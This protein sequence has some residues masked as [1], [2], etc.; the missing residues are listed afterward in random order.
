MRKILL[1]FSLSIII[2]SDTWCV[3]SSRTYFSAQPIFKPVSPEVL[4]IRREDIR[5][6]ENENY[7]TIDLTVFGGKSTN[8]NGLA[9]YF[10]P[11]GKSSILAGELGSRAVKSDRVDVI[12]NYFGVLTSNKPVNGD[13][14]NFNDYTF[15]SIVSLS[16]EQSYSGFGVVFRQHLSRYTDEGFW[17]SVTFP[18]INVKNNIGLTEKIIKRGGANGNNPK[19]PEGFYPNM[20]SAL[21]QQDWVFGK[22]KNNL[23]SKSGVSDLYLTIGY[24]SKKEEMYSLEGFVGASVPT[25]DAATAEFLFEPRVGNN[26]H[27]TIFSGTSMSFKVWQD[28]KNSVYYTFDTMGV[29]YIPNTQ[30]RSFDLKGKPWSRY[31]WVYLDSKSTTTS[32]GINVFTK[33]MCVDQGTQRDLN[34]AIIFKNCSGFEAEGGYHF[35]SRQS[36]KV[37]LARPWKAGPGIA[38]IDKDGKFT[39]GGVTRDNATINEY[40]GIK[41][42]MENGT[43]IFREIKQSDI[44]L[45]SAQHPAIISHILYLSLAYHWDENCYPKFIGAGGS[46]EFSE[47][48]SAL[49]R[50]MIWAKFG[51]YF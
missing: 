5:I 11:F 8:N 13:P 27:Y 12:A 10:L 44:D 42:D 6:Y 22:I 15:E 50:W 14:A 32:P 26:N 41:N 29:L 7:F 23:P 37:R 33:P 39:S 30:V 24:L 16:P 9:K 47:R 20:E 28:C 43:E 19:V 40:L 2:I 51:V 21:K 49:H 3:I 38:A 36:E 35:Y 4:S 18:F 34:T 48:N 17:Y 1:I 45:E 46:Y 31:M 25:E